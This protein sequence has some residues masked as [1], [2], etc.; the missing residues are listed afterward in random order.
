[1]IFYFIIIGL[2]LGASAGY[3]LTKDLFRIREENNKEKLHAVTEA[4]ND[5]YRQNLENMAVERI[6]GNGKDVS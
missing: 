5:L 2:F 4:Y 1:M 3:I 6:P